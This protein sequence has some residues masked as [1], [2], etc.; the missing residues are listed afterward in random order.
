MMPVLIKSQTVTVLDDETGQY[1]EKAT[2]SSQEPKAVVTTNVKGQADISVFRGSGKIDI[3]YMGYQTMSYSFQ[4]LEEQQF[5]VRMKMAGITL[6]QAVISATRWKEPRKEVPNTVHLLNM[7]EISLMN[8]QTAADVL[9]TDKG[10]FMQKSQMGGGSPMIRGYSA[11]RLLIVVDGVRMNSAI[12]RAENLQNVISIDPFS[13]DNIEILL[14]TGSVIYGSDALGGVMSF[15]SLTP[16]FSTGDDPLVS[17]KAITRYSSA[18]QEITGHFDVNV[19]WKKWAMATSVSHSRYGNLRMGSYGPDDYLRYSY[20]IRQDSV[21]RVVTNEDPLVQ[22]PTAYSQMNLMQKILFQP[23]SH[24]LFDYGLQ[25]SATTD[26]PRYDRHIRYK[27][28]IQRSA[29]WYYGPQIWMLNNLN[30]RQSGDCLL[31]DQLDLRLAHQH[32]EESRIDRDMNDAEKRHRLEKVDA[33]SANL[34]LVKTLNSKH[35]VYYGLELVSDKVKSKGTNE[36]ITTGVVSDG[37]SRYPQADW[38]SYA[39]YMM[40]KYRFH[41]KFM[42]EAGTR[43]N[44]F[45]MDADFDTTFYKFP[46]TE[47]HVDQGALTGSL[48]LDFYPDESWIC[49][50]L[51]SSGFRAPNVDDMGKVFDSQPGSVVMPNPDLKAEYAWNLEAGIEKTFGDWLKL[52]VTAYYTWLQDA[53]VVRS[54]TFNGQDSLLYDGTMCRV[55]AVQNAADAFVYGVE[56][57]VEAKL[58]DGFRLTSQLN[59]QKGE[60]EL[61]D[62]STSPL[63]AAAPLFGSSHLIL[64]VRRFS[65]NLYTVYTAER[66][67]KDMSVLEIEKPHLYAKDDNGNPYSPSWMTLNLKLQY[68]LNANWSIQAGMENITDRRY[69]PYSSG[70]AGPGRNFIISATAK[71]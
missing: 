28:G 7:K 35:T 50:L 23:N 56:A 24:W 10:V 62:G 1:M 26:Y 21:D 41:P 25:Y 63:R 67:F 14:G 43:Y 34:D 22:K 69:R 54:F 58:F 65:F 6:D 4:Q 27:N 61:E 57:G 13:M 33:L 59:Y 51:V 47:A 17:G 15:H 53:M 12:F 5:E 48:G 40:W 66:A 31:Y 3:R 49:R 70:I 55:K 64:D 8:L 42:L 32:F 71:F 60:E 38:A 18:N 45:S 68:A 19:G 9:G 46:F 37:P 16:A 30:V 20:V 29:E 2:L 39:A 36:D 11:N 52:D 44:G